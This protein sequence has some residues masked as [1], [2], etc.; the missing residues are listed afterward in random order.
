VVY[1]NYPAIWLEV[2]K[3]GQFEFASKEEAPVL[4]EGKVYVWGIGEKPY[5]TEKGYTVQAF[6]NFIVAYK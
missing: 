5:F 6:D 1:T 4:T 2:S 3:F